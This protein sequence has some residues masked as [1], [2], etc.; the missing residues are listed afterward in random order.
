MIKSEQLKKFAM[1]LELDEGLFDE[2]LDSGKYENQ[3]LSNIDYAKRFGVDKI[4][5]FKIINSEG[6]EHILKGGLP[7]DV[8]EKI[9]N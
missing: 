3:V 7:N 9:V 2:C 4:H 5:V 6:K 1:D 8:F